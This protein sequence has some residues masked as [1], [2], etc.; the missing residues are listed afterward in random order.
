[1][2]SQEVCA[3]HREDQLRPSINVGALKCQV[4]G[5]VP[6]DLG[7]PTSRHRRQ[8]RHALLHARHHLPVAPVV[9]RPAAIQIVLSGKEPRFDL[10]IP[11]IE[12]IVRNYS[13]APSA[14]SI[15]LAK[16]R[17]QQS[18]ATVYGNCCIVRV[19]HKGTLCNICPPRH[20]GI[21]FSRAS[22]LDE[23]HRLPP[24]AL[25][26]IDWGFAPGPSHEA[27]KTT[28]A[29]VS[30]LHSPLR[31]STSSLSLFNVRSCPCTCQSR[32][33]RRLNSEERNSAPNWLDEHRMAKMSL[34]TLPIEALAEVLAVHLETVSCAVPDG[35][36]RAVASLCRVSQR[37]RC[38]VA[39][40][41]V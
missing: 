9:Q 23:T 10:Q 38:A 33:R 25:R 5:K 35:Q 1:M 16:H 13:R 11:R 6:Y 22:G 17:P 18:M 40:T 19:R 29:P 36:L 39:S 24:W 30:C 4:H 27:Q 2:H 20:P 32:F 31:R 14:A 7:R 41:V 21:H 26:T 37:L 8:L 3:M 28:A 15:L 12:S 34:S